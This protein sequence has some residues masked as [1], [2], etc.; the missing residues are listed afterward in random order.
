[1]FENKTINLASSGQETQIKFDY[2]TM[3]QK[4]ITGRI[5]LQF[6]HNPLHD[7]T[8]GTQSIIGFQLFKSF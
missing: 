1:M 5:F 4:D 2:M 3:V 6:D 8:V 7:S